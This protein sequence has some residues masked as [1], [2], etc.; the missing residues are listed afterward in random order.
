M[1]FDL[2]LAPM[3]AGLCTRCG[4]SRL[5]F[6]VA[7]PLHRNSEGRQRGQS[8]A[9]AI[10]C[11]RQKATRRGRQAQEVRTD[12]VATSMDVVEQ[13]PRVSR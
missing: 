6:A 10:L 11:V 1:H 3:R 7:S 9:L 13:V 5:L 2:W 12:V 4:G 8:R